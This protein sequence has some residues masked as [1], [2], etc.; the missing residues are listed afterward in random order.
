MNVFLVEVDIFYFKFLDLEEVNVELKDIDVVI[1]VGVND[2]VNF[3]VEDDFGSF[4]YGMFVLQV[5]NVKQ[6]IVFKWSMCFGYVGIQNFL[7]F[8]EKI[9]MFFGDVKDL[10]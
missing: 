3:L 4:I 7:F 6:V 1:V 10:L 2:V 9:K 5:W 8:Y